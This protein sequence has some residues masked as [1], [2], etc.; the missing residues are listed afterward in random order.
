M[1]VTKQ[2][3]KLPR[4]YIT[5]HRGMGVT[6]KRRDEYIKEARFYPENSIAAFKE[7]IKIG[8]D[9]LECD[10]H[11]SSD[12]VAMVIHGEKITE[13]AYYIGKKSEAFKRDENK[14]CSYYTQ[15]QIQNCFV[16][17]G[18]EKLHEKEDR[19]QALQQSILSLAGD[20]EAYRIPTLKQLLEL[21]ANENYKREKENTNPLILNIELKG[22]KSGF[23]TL[24]TIIEFNKEKQ[25]SNGSCI[26]PVHIVLLGRMVVAEI[27]TAKNILQKAAQYSKINQSN[28]TKEVLRDLLGEN[29]LR[30]FLREQGWQL[31]LTKY[32]KKLESDSQNN[33]NFTTK[34]LVLTDKFQCYFIKNGKLIR[35]RSSEPANFVVK[36]D[37]FSQARFDEK[38]WIIAKDKLGMLEANSLI[39]TILLQ[40]PKEILE[41]YADIE[42]KHITGKIL[43]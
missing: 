30:L 4:L 31:I 41:K 21:V 28:F 11:V 2:S 5:A 8:A 26:N 18:K 6:A 40:A 35:Y 43:E 32:P 1:D 19:Q 3:L 20:P 42:Q 34:A 37:N 36:L 10:I 7:G 9:A 27:T 12:N 24:A 16:L 23:I 14:H 13:Y 15:N 38:D 33:F 29:E 25:K 22:Y 17:K 39:Q